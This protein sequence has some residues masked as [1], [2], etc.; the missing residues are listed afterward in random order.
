MTKYLDAIKN[1]KHTYFEDKVRLAME[2]DY[3]NSLGAS[4]F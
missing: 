2:T 1:F 4:F 3:L